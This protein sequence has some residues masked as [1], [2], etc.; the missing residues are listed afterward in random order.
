MVRSKAITAATCIAAVAALCAAFAC[1]GTPTS[2]SATINEPPFSGTLGIAGEAA[3]PF[4]VSKQGTV[5]ITVTAFNPQ[6]TIAL[7]VGLGQLTTSGCLLS[8]QQTV[9]VNEPVSFTGI[10]AGTYC[11]AIF[12]IGYVT[13]NNTFTL[14]ISHS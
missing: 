9:T 7:G 13:E 14:A 3:V 10:P 11:A 8:V 12:D 4:N 5:S 6:S 2:A 1:G